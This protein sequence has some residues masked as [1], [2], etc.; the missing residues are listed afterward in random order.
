[1]TVY[2]W[3]FMIAA[4]SAITALCGFCLF[5]LLTEEEDVDE[6]LDR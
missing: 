5:E 6:E 4:W 2:G 1:M 3:I